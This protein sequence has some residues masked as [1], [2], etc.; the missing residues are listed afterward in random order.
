MKHLFLS[1]VCL[2]Q[3]STGA[4][5]AQTV[6]LNQEK[7]WK[8]RNRF[9]EHFVKIGPDL[10]ESLPAGIRKPFDCVDTYDV[11]ID[12][13]GW[14]ISNYGEMHW[15][16]GMI[17]HGHYL[18][19]LST[20]YRLLENN[21][22]H[23]QAM[24]T[25]N[26]LYYALNAIFRLDQNA[27]ANQNQAQNLNTYYNPT[28]NGFY[29]REDVGEDFATL[30]WGTDR[31]TMR[32]GNS[33]FFSNNN[34][35]K[36]NDPANGLITK[37]NSYQNVPSLDQMTSLLV[38]LSMVNRFVD[39]YTVQP[40]PQDQPKNLV[41]FAKDLAHHIITY[42]SEN[43]WFLIDVNGW[44]VNNRGGDLVITAA[45]IL[46]IY[47]RFWP[48]VYLNTSAR[49]A[50]LPYAQVQEYITGYGLEGE[51]QLTADD[52]QWGLNPYVMGE[53]MQSNYCFPAVTGLYG[54][55][56][57]MRWQ[58][59]GIV[60]MN[61]TALN[62]LW[63]NFIPNHVSELYTDWQADGRFNNTGLGGPNFG[64]LGGINFEGLSWGEG[65]N[66]ILFGLGIAS[67]WWSASQGEQWAAATGNREYELIN[68][69]LNNLTPTHT[70]AFYR[71]YLDSLSLAGPYDL[72]A[73][74][75]NGSAVTN[76][77]EK[78]HDGGWGGEYRWTNYTQSKGEG[79]NGVFNAMDYMIFHNLFYLAFSNQLAP[80]K[81][82]W[83]CN[84]SGDLTAS[85][86]INEPADQL[87]YN[88]LNQ[89]LSYVDAC[90]ENVFYPVNNM[91]AGIFDIEPKFDNYSEM[92]I[93][94][95]KYQTENASVL[96]T[97][98]INVRTQFVICNGTLNVQSGGRIDVEVKDM[99]VNTQGQ[100]DNSGEILVRA[101]TNL[102][103]KN[104]SKLRLLN[105][106]KLKIEEGA[107]VIIEEGASIEY[108]NGAEIQLLG[109]NAEI[110][111][112]GTIR[113][114][115][116][117]TF[118]IK[119][120]VSAASKGKLTITSPNA[121]FTANVGAYFKLEGF[122]FNDPFITINSGAQL[123]VDDPNILT[124]RVAT[125][126]VE[127]KQGASVSFK[128][129]FY[130]YDVR[131][132]STAT[133]GG[134]KV[135]NAHVFSGC[136]F[137]NVPVK[138]PNYAPGTASL[139][140]AA[141]NCHFS[142][143]SSSLNTSDLAL[144]KV[145]GGGYTISNSYFKGARSYCIESSSMT[146]ASSISNTEFT[147]LS[148]T[149]TGATLTGVQDVS[150][151]ELK[152]TSSIFQKL[153]YGVN[154]SN[155]KLTLKCNYFG[156]N[157]LSNIRAIA[158]CILNMSINDFG[159]YNNLYKS[160]QNKSIEINN[161]TVNLK[162]GYN[163]IESCNS[164]IS[165]STSF[166]CIPPGCQ[167]DLAK[168]QWNTANSVPSTALFQI[169]SA[170]GY[171]VLPL[172]TTVAAKPACGYYDGQIVVGPPRSTFD[173]DGM[174]I[175][176]S[177]V[178][179]DSIRLDVAIVNA[180][181]DMTTYDDSTGN[182]LRAINRFNEI[183]TADLDV[184][185]SLTAELLWFSLPHMKTALE[186]AF[187]HE[188][189]QTENNVSSY[190]GYVGKYAAALTRMNPETID[191]TNYIRQFY[192]EIDKAHL[193][194]MI[195]HPNIGLNI[196]NE[197]ESCG[198]DSAE[199]THLNYWKQ[200]FETDVV[201]QQLGLAALDTTIVIDTAG[202][203][204]PAL[205]SNGY[206]FGAIINDLNSI[207]YPNCDFYAYRDLFTLQNGMQVFPNPATEEVRISWEASEVTGTGKLLIVQTDGRR[208]YEETARFD[209]SGRTI[210]I[211]TWKRGAYIVSYTDPS[212][213]VHMK[214]LVVQ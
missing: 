170:N 162:D 64:G 86:P 163:F 73:G 188:Q 103:L 112:G 54:W 3:V 6:E 57:F 136:H 156:N 55:S 48:G 113:V 33:P 28:V 140:F 1:V 130:N 80:Y 21:G 141:S 105:G 25:L 153:Q 75:W 139:T 95:T 30:N 49:R 7:Y 92:G 81:P 74:H 47:N 201:I 110:Q 191:S 150:N 194:R 144:L 56:P 120:S 16:D 43:N 214:Q 175:F 151:V 41:L 187:I 209:E 177:P 102:I 66:S 210:N 111:M 82:S 203:L 176:Y 166:T 154:K 65:N 60:D 19:L 46:K 143:T 24:A 212:G 29:N 138:V 85:G 208:V 109:G 71:Q 8:F 160:L 101:G 84:C 189:L 181:L 196:L 123:K 135:G 190:D 158:G 168:N 114:M 53:L 200:V 148:G 197:L 51:S 91:V 87:A 63:Q 184:T 185:D 42:A 4:S 38:G 167:V 52:M 164:T 17:R 178:Y 146:V 39:G 97:G 115:D 121:A 45:P 83:T 124:F 98:D 157:N 68:C 119:G 118:E 202:Y 126:S 152:I 100:V 70:G 174:P 108:S 205:V 199:Q 12:G 22:Q 31:M 15:G 94:T 50:I 173:T 142:S 186:S 204:N 116:A 159:G 67:G 93:Y 2:W 211:S 134:L 27:E 58:N 72:A 147:N 155:G 34:S 127:L 9:K 180:M 125:T 192:H 165:G 79:D 40:T 88:T 206:S 131:Y 207:Q 78:Y 171:I 179:E 61:V 132:N 11:D 5:Y 32:C 169:T 77:K 99:I 172:V 76:I 62:G 117:T 23:E 89:K 37:G 213:K 122:G 35:G 128:R 183:F 44:P 198:L 133:N 129:P 96:P 161:C 107:K 69:L 20:E 182:D 137:V 13:T 145:T 193:L 26:E 106:S 104:G 90:Q 149:A 36:I 14:G 10:G 18:T 59:C 195:G